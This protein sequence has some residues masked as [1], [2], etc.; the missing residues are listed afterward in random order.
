M[1]PKSPP[2]SVQP[3]RPV[4]DGLTLMVMGSP[5]AKPRARGVPG[6]RRPVSMTGS[7]KRYATALVER[8]RVAVANLGGAGVLAAAWGDGAVRVDILCVIA[9]PRAER[10]GQPHTH[11]PD[12]DNLEKMVLDCLTKAGALGGDDSRASQGETVKIWGQVGSMAVMVKPVGP[13][14]RPAAAASALEAAPPWLLR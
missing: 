3:A 10:W 4:V 1:T 14:A 5:K 8:A 2:K 12:K 7:A 6:R 13:G 9:T 11:K